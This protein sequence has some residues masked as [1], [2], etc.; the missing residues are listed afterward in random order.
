MANKSDLSKNQ[1]MLTGKLREKGYDWWWHSLTAIE[2][3]TGKERPFFIEYYLCN[4]GLMEEDVILGQHP[5]RKKDLKKPSYMMVKAGWWGEN[6]DQLHRFIPWSKV[7]IN[8]DNHLDLAAEDCLCTETQ[9]KGSVAVSEE[10]A[11]KHPEYMCGSGNMEWD[12]AV[13]KKIAFNVGYGSSP[14]FRKMN[15]FE[16]F[17]HAEGMKTAYSGTIKLNG[18]DYLVS[19]ENCYGYADKNWGSDFTSPWVW[20]ASNNLESNITGDKLNNSA[21]VI[22]GGRPKIFGM[23]LN[24]KLLSN[25]HYE[26][27]DY[28]FNFSKFWTFCQTEFNCAISEHQI[29]WYV[30][31]ETLKHIYELYATCEKKDMLLLNYEAPNGLKLHNNLYNGGNGVGNMQLYKKDKNER[32]LIDS[33]NAKN[34]GCEYGEYDKENKPKTK[35]LR[36]NYRIRPV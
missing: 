26:G 9:I 7:Q 36:N 17:W 8:S 35:V 27:Q 12:L 29:D 6:A 28:E 16:M 31:Q 20:L 14:I 30:R 33:I 24:R 19:P 4:P 34:I 1:Y 5:D 23:P 22:G 25:I 21:F 32:Q 11:K 13:D 10:E 18:K 2:K 15:A 3:E